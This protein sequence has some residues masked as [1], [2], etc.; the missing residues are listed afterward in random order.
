M[1]S[2]LLFLLIAMIT[3]LSP[4]PGVIL[5]LTNTIRFGSKNA[6]QGIL[7]IAFGTFIIAGVSATSLGIL[8]AT[9]A[10]AFTVMKLIGAAYLIYLG[11]KLWRSPPLQVKIDEKSTKNK[12]LLFIEGMTLQLTNPKAIFFFISVFPQFINFNVSSTVQFL[13]LVVTYS[14][15]VII[16]HLLYSLAAKSARAWFTTAKGSNWLNKISGSTFMCFGIGLGVASKS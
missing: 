14:S 8:L 7:G 5:T 3:I 6:L 12:R 15:L 2:Y 11:I 1:E 4:G 16:I 10:L 13:T 9:S